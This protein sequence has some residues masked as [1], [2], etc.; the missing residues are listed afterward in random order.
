MFMA[1]SV[2]RKISQS[3]FASTMQTKNCSNILWPI[4]LELSRYS[5]TPGL[6][7]SHG[8]SSF[9]TLFLKEE[10]CHAWFVMFNCNLFVQDEYVSEGLQWSFVKYQDNQSCLD[11]IEGSPSIF[12]LL[13]EVYFSMQSFIDQ[14]LQY[15]AV[16]IIRWPTDWI[17]PT[18]PD[19]DWILK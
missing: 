6:G 11:L 7:S 9:F 2:F 8:A 15:T 19:S 13:N 4:I 12:S 14:L 5:S 10:M 3:S 17:Q 16:V 1:L 18:K